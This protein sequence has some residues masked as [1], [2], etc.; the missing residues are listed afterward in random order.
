MAEYERASHFRAGHLFDTQPVRRDL[1]RLLLVFLADR[2]YARVTEHEFFADGWAQPLLGLSS[3]FADDEITRALLSS[4]IALRVI[5]DRDGDVLDRC[6]PCGEL[7]VNID[8]EEVE[9]LSLREACNKIVHAE[10]VHFDVE[11]LDGGP[12]EQIGI[13]PTFIQ[14]F[15]YLYGTHRRIQWRCVLDIVGYVRSAVAAL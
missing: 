15:V 1:W 3:D 2:E 8:A 13:S 12:I 5:D 9:P 10:R 6:E 4:A 14:P 7:R 11:R